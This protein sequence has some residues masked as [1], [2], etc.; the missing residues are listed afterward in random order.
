VGRAKTPVN[1]Q[2]AALHS[3]TTAFLYSSLIFV[4]A[5]VIAGLVLPRG[6]MRT[7]SRS[8]VDRTPAD[9]VAGERV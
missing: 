4:V 6:N 1:L 5:A 2:S 3:Y 8:A 7:L 9:P